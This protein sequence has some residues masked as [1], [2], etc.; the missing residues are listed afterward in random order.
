[1]YPVVL[2]E[3]ACRHR[4]V[5]VYVGHTIYLRDVKKRSPERN[6]P[7]AITFALSP[8]ARRHIAFNNTNDKLQ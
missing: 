1:M 4:V 7:E 5:I 2:L 6:V 3:R 8:T